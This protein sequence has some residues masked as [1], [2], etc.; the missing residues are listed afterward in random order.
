MNGIIRVKSKYLLLGNT[1]RLFGIACVSVV[2]RW[3]LAL[4]T[5]FGIYYF[6][7]NTAV[8][9]FAAGIGD[10]LF[11]II[12]FVS[13]LLVC[14]AV[15]IFCAAVRLG[16]QFV[17]FTRAN[18]G[19]GRFALLFRFCGIKKSFR[20]FSLYLKMNILKFGWL[21]YYLLPC[22]VCGG[23]VYYLYISARLSQEVLT[24]LICGIS[25]LAALALFMWRV[26]VFR[27]S[28]APYYMCLR[29]DL[30][31]NKAIN[32][33]IRFTDGYLR[34]GMLLESSFS[35]WILSCF[36][37]IPLIYVLPYC[38]LCRAVFVT[39][40]VDFVDLKPEKSKYAVNFL[41]IESGSVGCCESD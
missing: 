41:K 24:V 23:M 29:A 6:A 27:Y 13:V 1:G 22:G 26:S 31:V 40:V 14:T 37:V 20:A 11:Y 3:G 18:Y 19:K 15:A 25:L 16:E 30:G 7:K 5:A 35:G 4:F 38:K 10:T 17:F 39:D 32:K 12:A 9:D 8:R 21:L 33:S 28:A 36:A 2:L 34:E